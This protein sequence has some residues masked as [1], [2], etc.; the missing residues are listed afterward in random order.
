MPNA[1]SQAM[2]SEEHVDVELDEVSICCWEWLAICKK[3][4]NVDLAV[5]ID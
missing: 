4:E 3:K 1:V 2:H 5:M